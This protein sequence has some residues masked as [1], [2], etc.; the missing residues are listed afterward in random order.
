ML[1]VSGLNV[2]M[3]RGPE[4]GL[5]PAGPKLWAERARVHVCMQTRVHA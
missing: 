5:P 1:T 2:Q 4:G 3:E